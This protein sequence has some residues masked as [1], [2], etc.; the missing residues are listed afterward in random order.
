MVDQERREVKFSLGSRKTILCQKTVQEWIESM[1]ILIIILSIYH[2][3][4]KSC[5]SMFCLDQCL[6]WYAK[7]I[8]NWHLEY[9][10]YFHVPSLRNQSFSKLIS[11]FIHIWGGMTWLK[12]FPVS[13]KMTY[14]GF[15]TFIFHQPDIT[16]PSICTA[17]VLEINTA[18]NCLSSPAVWFNGRCLTKFPSFLFMFWWRDW[19]HWKKSSAS[20]HSGL[21]MDCFLELKTRTKKPK[22]L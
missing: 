2:I 18:A 1:E 15:H 6:A 11:F 14:S 9:I 4:C 22:E 10:D 3:I 20:F 5:K 12:I 17:I 21:L 13:F 7:R 16:R 19:V 8:L